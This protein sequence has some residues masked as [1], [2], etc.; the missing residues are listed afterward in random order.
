[1][2]KG[3]VLEGGALRGLFTA[4]ILDVL[5][6]HDIRFDGLVGVS[7]G[8]CFGCNYKSH[9]PGRVLRYN[10]RF[11]HDPRYCSIWSLIT[12]GGIYGAEFGYYRLPEQLDLFDRKTF[13]QDPMAF[14]L[15]CTDVHTGKAVYRRI[16]T[17]DRELSDWILAS[18]SMP[19][20]SKIVH[21]GDQD[22]LDGGIADSIPLRYFQ[23]QGYERNLVI[24]TQPSDYLKGPLR[25]SSLIRRILRRYPALVNAWEHRHE[26]Y[27]AELS[28]VAEQQSLGNALVLCPQE[29]LPISHISH[30]RSLMRKT[31]QMGHDL[32]ESQLPRILDF[33]KA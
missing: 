15:V 9:Q 16:D 11:A 12:T 23:E 33:I 31:Y 24:L 13:E 20:V 6:Q 14:H 3:L 17:G 29:P 25:W 8:A 7:A 30:N 21:I 2:K 27:N 28:Y 5:M 4:G 18:S 1:M 26:M 32:A 10:L 19:V 22:L